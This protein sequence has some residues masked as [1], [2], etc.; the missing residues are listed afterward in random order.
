[1]HQARRAVGDSGTR[2]G[3]IRTIPRA[4]FR[5]VADLKGPCGEHLAGRQDFVG[6][7]EALGVIDDA[8]AQAVADTRTTLMI[9]GEPGI[10]KTR[11]AELACTRARKSGFSVH[12]SQC[13]EV[14][15]APAYWPWIQLLRSI[16]AE[17]PVDDLPASL[18]QGAPELARLVPELAQRLPQLDEAPSSDPGPARFLLFDAVSSLIRLAASTR[19]LLLM[20]DDLHKA[21]RSS[22]MLLRDVTLQ[23]ANTAVAVLAT[24]REAELA[25][26]PVRAGLIADLAR[27]E[28]AR[29]IQLAGLRA[30]EVAAFVEVHTGRTPSEE[31]RSDLHARTNGN[32]FFLHQ[33]IQV[34]ESEGRAFAVE[35]ESPLRFRLPRHAQDAITRQIA[36]LPDEVTSTLEVASVIGREF[37]CKCL[38]RVVSSSFEAI[39]GFL[40]TARV[41]GLVVEDEQVQLQFR[42]AHV[43]LRDAIYESIAPTRRA[44]L[45]LEVGV[46]LL[47]LQE[48]EG[49]PADLA[50]VSHHFFEGARGE[51]LSQAIDIALRAG[52][53]ACDHFAFEEAATSFARAL[54]L[55]HRNEGGEHP[56]RCEI[57]LALGD[58]HTWAG[59]RDDARECF[60]A[61]ARLAKSKGLPEA[62]AAAALRFAPDFLA[63]ET[64]V[65][66]PELVS[67]LEDAIAT[68][69]ASED[70]L[71]ARLL[72]RLA[73][74]LHWAPNSDSQ[75][76][77]LCSAAREIAERSGDAP[78]RRYVDCAAKLAMYSIADP[79]M[80]LAPSRAVD[81]PEDA[82]VVLLEQLLRATSLLQIGDLGAYLRAAD[83]FVQLAHRLRQPQA[84][85]YGDLFRATHACLLGRFSEADIHVA[86]FARAG[87]RAQDR[88][89]LLSQQLQEFLVAIDRGGVERFEASLQ[90][91]AAQFPDLVG[92]RGA[93][94]LFFAETGRRAE[95]A[96]EIDRILAADPGSLPKRNEW[97]GMVTG[98][99]LAAVEVGHLEGVEMA[100]HLARPH[101]DELVVTGYASFCWGAVS[102]MLGMVAATSGDADGAASYFERAVEINGGLGAIPALARTRFYEG[103][104]RLQA[105]DRSGALSA[106][107]EAARLAAALGLTR[108][109]AKVR[110]LRA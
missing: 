26:D 107:D 48:E 29:R 22:L 61:V 43:L 46:V 2:Q 64:G 3:V 19:P 10:G 63:I 36:S 104:M 41:A 93:L 9:S 6:R 81:G 27:A 66:D 31:V 109:E 103:R 32:P 24:H 15:G 97:L 91:V 1:M 108:L 67:L 28:G 45:H 39:Q 73:V 40:D 68:L 59:H 60:K 8:L 105:G 38:S 52:R 89:V 56:Q 75:R 54:E 44:G 95:A 12:L 84:S 71:R 21:D 92:W 33:V 79:H 94:A 25:L 76:R 47:R 106:L 58:A 96:R 16:L 62:I 20:I 88:N 17:V 101:A 51:N 42:F 74:A 53:W 23:L 34:L 37:S 69:P 4:G 35:H 72:G 49:Q 87:A 70:V 77:S 18:G 80:Y 90:L 13:A 5:F 11:I 30:K 85:W 82:T 14:E 57:L 100:Y 110:E 7:S 50:N 102:A 78:T 86:R 65:H 98:L 99:G 55:C 83:E